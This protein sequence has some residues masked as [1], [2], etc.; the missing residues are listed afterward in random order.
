MTDLSI[1]DATKIYGSAGNIRHTAEPTQLYQHNVMGLAE[2]LEEMKRELEWQRGIMVMMRDLIGELTTSSTQRVFNSPLPGHGAKT[3]ED[4][5]FIPFDL[6]RPCGD[7]HSYLSLSHPISLYAYE[8]QEAVEYI[9]EI[10]PEV[11]TE[12]VIVFPGMK[13]QKTTEEE[14]WKCSRQKQAEQM[15]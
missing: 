5:K 15:R 3:V 11:E 4:K 9:E 13:E 8:F 10:E 1:F 14:D 7:D 6:S 12:Q 2:T